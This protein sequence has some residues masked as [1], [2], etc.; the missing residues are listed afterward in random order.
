[1][2]SLSS[3]QVLKEK[4]TRDANTITS[5]SLTHRAL[6]DISCLSEFQNLE[7]LDLAFNNLTSL[8]GLSSCVK[9]KWLSVVQNKLESLKG[10]ESLSN[11]TVLNAGKNK[12]KL[13]DEVRSLVSLRALILNDNEIVS[14]CKL[15]QMKELNTLVLSRN[16]IREIGESLFKVKSMTKANS[17]LQ[18]SLSNC[19]LQTIGSS[20]KSCIEL[21]ELRL[22]H[23][24]IKTLP[25]ELAYNKK[26]QNLD[27][28]N[29]LITR[30]SDVKVLSSLVDLKN[31]NLLGNPIA[32][33]AK[34][35]KKV[36]KFSPN[37]HV[38]NARPVDK[39]ARNEISGGADDSSLIPTN[40]LDYHSEKKKD[41]TRDVNSSKHV[42]DQRR[43][44]FDNASDD[45]E[46]DLRQKRKKTKGK[47]SKMEE[48]STDEKDDAVIE[49]KLKRKKPHVE[50]LKNNDDKIH[51]DDRTKVEKKLKSKKS[52]KELSELDI[53]DNGEVS[54]AELF[55]VDA[56]EYLK[57][58]IESKTADK[59]G[60]NALGGLLTVSAKKKKTKNQGLV[61]TVPMS[62]AVEV[63]M[64]GP[65]TWG[66]E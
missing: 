8:Q 64:G 7:R 16:P 37:L 54:F 60:I 32:E 24:D 17:C 34:I 27:L 31:L 53:I 19:H 3:Q 35:T 63:G 65:S 25:A 29:N 57:H 20:L 51:N 5:I 52:R 45:V 39:S 30:W 62:P 50:L 43:D 61:S 28:G 1:M 18:L 21:K 15:D 33:N 59:S 48:A 13:I 23:N 2:A 46:K 22:A 38:F 14:I 36:Q 58:N 56:V 4:Q 9:L 49:K 44:H 40:E 26:L 55:S 12:I 42:T 47:V 66:D 6:S 41:H 10:I 11:L